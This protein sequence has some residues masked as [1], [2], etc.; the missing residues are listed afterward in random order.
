[1]SLFG[2]N[3]GDFYKKKDHIRY[4]NDYEEEL[5]TDEKGKHHRRAVYIGPYIPIENE[6]SSLRRILAG[7]VLL[8]L[9]LVTALVAAMFINHTTGWFFLTTI[10]MAAAAFP[11]LYLVMGVLNLPYSGKPMQRDKY[12]HGIIRMFRS[13]GALITIIAVT[14][15]SEFVY[16]II[17]SDWMFLRGDI[18]F[19]LLLGAVLIAC[20]GIILLLRA[21]EVNEIELNLMK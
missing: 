18:I 21:I 6:I 12:M 10:P 14:F 15:V 17:Y 13:S 4:I 7:V 2:N 19:M 9:A 20:I 5:Y 8:A 3:F 16:R 11:A 1:M